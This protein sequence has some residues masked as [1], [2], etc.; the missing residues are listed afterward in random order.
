[1]RGVTATAGPPIA[2]RRP[3][4]ATAAAARSR[5]RAPAINAAAAADAPP[6][7][8]G[9][10][11]ATTKWALT[12][13]PQRVRD[14]EL[15]MFGVVNNGAYAHFFQDARHLAL[16]QLTGTSVAA[17][18]EGGTL[19]ALSEL[20]VRYRAPLRSGDSYVCRVGVERVG[21]ARV[22][23]AQQVVRVVVGAA[24]AGAAAAGAGA[25]VAG[26]AAGPGEGE[27]QGIDGGEEEVLAAEGTAT[28]VFLDRRY[29]PARM[30]A[31]A[32]RAFEEALVPPPQ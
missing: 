9:G 8:G 18:L 4:A 32:R 20:V 3:G 15:D 5:Q 23:L 26:A 7:A 14:Y 10:A 13:P 29:R 19:M 1:M 17:F 28:V 6:I 30:P 31:E 27:G 21:G 16:E 25:G 11:R 12:T 2:R 22:T 24:A